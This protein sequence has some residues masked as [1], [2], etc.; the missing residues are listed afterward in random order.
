MSWDFDAVDS[1][2]E[3]LGRVDKDWAGLA[4]ELFTDGN[5]YMVKMD[6][7]DDAARVLSYDERATLLA[8]A[9]TIDNDYFSHHS[10]SGYIPIHICT[11]QVCDG[12]CCVSIRY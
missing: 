1:N 11:C 7:L 4:R 5:I 8:T 6:L 9:I 3:R 12:P 10:R 2:G